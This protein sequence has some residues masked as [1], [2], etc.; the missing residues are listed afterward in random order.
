M[1]SLLVRSLPTTVE[2]LCYVTTYLKEKYAFYL[3]S[4]PFRILVKTKAVAFKVDP[5]RNVS[6]SD[7]GTFPLYSWLS[8]LKSR[9]L[10]RL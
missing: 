3:S 5:L 10:L 6:F 9:L 2:N 1:D 7:Q 4:T 8:I